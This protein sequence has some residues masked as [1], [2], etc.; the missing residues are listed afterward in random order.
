MKTSMREP[1]KTTGEILREFQRY[2]ELNEKSQAT[3][4]KYLHDIQVF[5]RR[6]EDL[7][8][9]RKEQVI[10]YKEWLIQHYAVTSANSM[11]TAANQFLRFIG[12][13]DCCVKLF[14]MQYRTFCD[15]RTELSRRE[16]EQM[17][18]AAERQG[19]TRLYFVLQTLCATG[20]RISELSSITVEALERGCAVT[21]NKGKS[22][23]ILI[24]KGLCRILRHY[25]QQ[26]GVTTG[27]V[28]VTRCGRPV[29]RSN[30]WKEM[31]RLCPNAAVSKSKVYPHNLRHLFARTFYEKEKDIMHLAD[32]LGHQSVNTTRIYVLSDGEGHRA[33]IEDLDLFVLK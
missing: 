20:I 29:D 4:R 23:L 12:A 28:F 24:P 22:R 27:P 25:A 3:I 8:H 6:Q 1:A 13:E 15:N 26:R 19:K 2:L 16:Y 17:L 33:Q 10:A 5:L 9:V 7:D 31:K 14:R 30:V 32:I 18:R 11:L 21:N